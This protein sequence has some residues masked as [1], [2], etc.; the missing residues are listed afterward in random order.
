MDWISQNW[1]TLAALGVVAVTVV[2]FVVRLV[3][4]R[5]KG[6]CGKNCGCHRLEGK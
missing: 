6:A 5:R 4:P 2:V 1:Q 3:R